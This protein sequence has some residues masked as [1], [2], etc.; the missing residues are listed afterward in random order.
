VWDDLAPGGGIVFART[1]DHGATWVGAGTGTG[2]PIHPITVGAWYPEINVAG[3]GAIYLASIAGST[4]H[5]DVSHDGGDTFTA[6]PSPATGITTLETSLP[7]P[8]G[9]PILPGGNFRVITDPTACAF[10]STVL[11]AWADYREGFSRIY[12]AR[13]V[14]G[15]N[16]WTTGP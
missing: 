6:A 5:L 2:Q 4:I 12:F 1:K 16:S 3:D 10:G 7:A 15:G 11:V 13:S 8:S 9:F 14:D